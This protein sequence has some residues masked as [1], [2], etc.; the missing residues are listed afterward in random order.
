MN[1]MNSCTGT[2]VAACNS[3]KSIEALNASD[4]IKVRIELEK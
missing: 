3:R 2:N 4:A 1:G